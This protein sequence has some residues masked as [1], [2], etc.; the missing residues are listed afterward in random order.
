MTQK[1]MI[2]MGLGNPC[3]SCPYSYDGEANNN[4][5]CNDCEY[6]N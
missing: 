5:A 4:C 3:L 2:A 6:A 1:Q